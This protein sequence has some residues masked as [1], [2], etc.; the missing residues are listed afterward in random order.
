MRAITWNV[1][2]VKPRL[3]RLL[4]LLEREQ[5][6][7]VCLQEVKVTD[8]AFPRME[9]SG[10]GYVALV[11]GQATYN[12]VAILARSEPEEVARSFPG[13][14]TPE[15]ARMLAARVGDVTIVSAYVIN[16]RAVGDPW[17]ERKLAWLR[18][19][20]AWVAATFDPEEPLLIAGDFNLAPDERDVWDPEA[21]KGHCHFTPEEHAEF[22][23]LTAWGLVDLFRL[24]TAEGG[25]FTW[26][27]YRAGAFHKKEGLRIDLMLGTEPLARRCT[28]VRIDRN[29]RRPKAGPGA[30][31]DHAPVIAT[32]DEQ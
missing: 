8:E 29:E 28:E 24:H 23:Q 10:A 19:V 13:D 6:D 5:P 18:G 12:G 3:E 26:W 31:S 22:Q 32:F 15:D 11:N 17:F 4:A 9:L 21:W 7:L 16:G 14:P 2:G 30:P 25:R 27:D 1:N 20:R